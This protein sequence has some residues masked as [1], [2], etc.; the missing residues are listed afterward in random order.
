MSGSSL[1]F[2]NKNLVINMVTQRRRKMVPAIAKNLL[3]MIH[4]EFYIFITLKCEQ[5]PNLCLWQMIMVNQMRRRVMPVSS[6]ISNAQG[7]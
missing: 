5:S 2:V 4:L 3:A 7:M 1:Y 6:V